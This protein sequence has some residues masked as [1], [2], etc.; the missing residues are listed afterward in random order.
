[1][2]HEVVLGSIYAALKTLLA[3]TVP[4]TA[5]LAT[6][7]LGGAP[8][9]YDEGSVPQAATSTPGWRPYLTIGAGTQ[10]PDHMMGPDGSARFGWNCTLQIKA[11]GQIAEADGLAI[12]SQV[13][14]AL[15]DGKALT[16]P[17]Y[18]SSWCEEFSLFPT[19]VTIAGAV[20]TREFPAIGRVFA[21]DQA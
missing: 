2:P 13:F 21:S 20:V 16:L 17:G 7:P 9:I 3:S 4:L 10:V 1:M 5:L 12:M 8:A 18:A 19:I 14:A 15:P 6:K 11:V